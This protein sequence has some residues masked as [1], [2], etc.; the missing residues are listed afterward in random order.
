MFSFSTYRP[1]NLLISL[2]ILYSISGNASGVTKTLRLQMKNEFVTGIG[3]DSNLCRLFQPPVDR[4]GNFWVGMKSLPETNLKARFM[5]VHQCKKTIP[6]GLFKNYLH[7]AFECED[8]RFVQVL[9][10][11]H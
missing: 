3:F 4:A 2:I 10:R 5:V 8:S 9:I 1:L 7:N 11:D 6:E